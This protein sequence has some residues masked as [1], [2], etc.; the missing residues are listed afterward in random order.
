[1]RE[2]PKLSYRRAEVLL[3]DRGWYQRLGMSRVPDHVTLC[4]AFHYLVTHQHL[5]RALDLLAQAMARAGV[6]GKILALDSTCYDIRP[7]RSLGYVTPLAFAQRE[8][9]ESTSPPGWRSSRPPASFRPSLAL[10]YD[11]EQLIHL[12]RLTQVLGQLG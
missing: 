4:R 9:P 6:I 7:H 5:D 12:A 10:L 3:R 1:V 11:L 2:Q 8:E